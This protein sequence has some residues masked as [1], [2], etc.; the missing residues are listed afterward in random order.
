MSILICIIA[1]RISA[2]QNVFPIT[3]DAGPNGAEIAPQKKNSDT[4][5][6]PNRFDI[7][8]PDAH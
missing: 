1:F 4:S 6:A 5:D 7:G 3:N 2:P 8:M